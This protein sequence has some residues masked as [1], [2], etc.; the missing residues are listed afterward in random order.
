MP[1]HDTAKHGLTGRTS[2]RWKGKEAEKTAGFSGRCSPEDKARWQAA[3]DASGLKLGQ[4]INDTLN[5][6]TE[7]P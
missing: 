6:A 5:A 4:W 1:S 7:K 3:A 2:N